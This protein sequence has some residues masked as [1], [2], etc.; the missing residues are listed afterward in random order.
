M[1]SNNPRTRPPRGPRGRSLFTWRET[2]N[3]RDA[4]DVIETEVR[5]IVEAH[6]EDTPEGKAL[7]YWRLEAEMFRSPAL[8][9][10]IEILRLESCDATVD[11]FATN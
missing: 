9:M 2:V 10:A 6:G 5:R 1:D 4:L 7:P 8:L 3:R 11:A